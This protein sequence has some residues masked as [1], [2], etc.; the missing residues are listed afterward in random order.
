M[1]PVKSAPLLPALRNCTSAQCPLR[2][3]TGFPPRPRPPPP[4]AHKGVWG[5]PI[6]DRSEVS[7]GLGKGASQSGTGEAGHTVGF[8]SNW[9][10]GAQQN[11][12]NRLSGT[13]PA[14]TA[15]LRQAGPF[16]CG[17]SLSHRSGVGPSNSRPPWN[18]WPWSRFGANFKE[19]HSF[20][21]PDLLSQTSFHVY[22]TCS[23][24]LLPTSS[25]PRRFQKTDLRNLPLHKSIYRECSV[26][27]AWP[28][29]LDR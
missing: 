17:D 20:T 9:K 21:V 14:M 28:A 15:R 24:L 7:P 1:G 12:V 4:N 2:L 19:L 18:R 29:S 5:W 25:S 8:L 23:A 3:L 13:E 22:V 6:C 10:P 11:P 16:R 27:A 26:M